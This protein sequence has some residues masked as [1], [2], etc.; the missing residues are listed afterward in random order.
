MY[1]VG[2]VAEM[3]RQSV[4]E[5]MMVRIFEQDGQDLHSRRFGNP[6]D[7]GCSINIVFFLNFFDVSE[8]C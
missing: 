5:G 7:T 4:R 2:L 8:L 1:L 6:N 3:N